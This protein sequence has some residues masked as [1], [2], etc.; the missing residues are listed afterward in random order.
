MADKNRYWVAVMWPDDMR[1]DWQDSI[2][3]IVQ[4]PFSYCIHDKDFLSPFEEQDPAERKVHVHVLLV[5]PNT[6][7]FK[8]ALSVFQRLNKDDCELHMC[9]SVLNVRHMYEYLIHN[10]EECRKK[11]KHQYDS[12]ERICGNNFDI[13]GFEQ[14]SKD[15]KNRV[16]YEICNLIIHNGFCN[17]TEFFEFVLD[18]YDPATFDCIEAHSGLYDRLCK[19]NYLRIHG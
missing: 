4:L 5:F 1:E 19:G 10:T 9:K 13:G 12:S 2:G 8:H 15:E 11:K 14:L 18:K 7:T 16:S 17:F 6:T 3:D